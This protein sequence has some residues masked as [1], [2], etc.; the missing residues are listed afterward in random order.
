[1]ARIRPWHVAAIVAAVC[2][3]L[4]LI[5]VLVSTVRHHHQSSHHGEVYTIEYE[6]M[7]LADGVEVTGYWVGED[8]YGFRYIALYLRND[9]DQ[10]LSELS[11]GAN[12]C[13]GEQN[14]VGTTYLSGSYRLLP[15]Q[16]GALRGMLDTGQGEELI[17][18][19]TVSYTAGFS[20]SRSYYY[21]RLPEAEEYLPMNKTGDVWYDGEPTPFSGSSLEG[22]VTFQEGEDPLTVESMS[23]K[24]GGDYDYSVTLR[25]DT[26]DKMTDP[27]VYVTLLDENGAIWDGFYCTGSGSLG[28]GESDTFTG[29]AEDPHCAYFTVENYSY[30]TGRSTYH[31]GS[32][33]RVPQAVPLTAET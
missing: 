22:P 6:D 9:T 4:C 2:V 31:S 7:D 19:C 29:L 26:Q 17:Q 32:F 18:A 24:S 14:A 27:M 33:C 5:F 15:G 21:C 28:P 1:M 20:E 23:A 11:V 10:V 12:V 16:T 3:H 13:D 8:E 25:N 30:Y